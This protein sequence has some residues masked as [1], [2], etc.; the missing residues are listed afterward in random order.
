MVIVMSKKVFLELIIEENLKRLNIDPRLVDSFK[1]VMFKI[2]QYFDSHGYSEKIDFETIVN[3]YLL[4][5]ETVDRETIRRS[6]KFIKEL[7]DARENQKQLEAIVSITL[8]PIEEETFLD[9]YIKKNYNVGL[10]FKV[11]SKE[12]DVAYAGIYKDNVKTIEI[13]ESVL[14]SISTIGLDRVLCHEFIHFLTMCGKEKLGSVK[15]TMTPAIYEPLTEMLASDVIGIKPESYKSY[16]ELIRYINLLCGVNGFEYFIQR[17][18]DPKYEAME[19][20]FEDAQNIFDKHR[21]SRVF[22]DMEEEEFNDLVFN[23]TTQL[24]FRDYESVEELT[25]NLVKIYSAPQVYSNLEGYE[26]LQDGIV[27]MYLSEHQIT[28]PNVKVKIMQLVKVKN[29]R[30]VMNNMNCISLNISGDTY[31]FDENGNLYL[32]RLNTTFK[33]EKQGMLISYEVV[34]GV[35]K[36]YTETGLYKCDLNG[37][38]FKALG[39]NLANQQE[40][41]ER[42]IDILIKGE[43][44][45][46]PYINHDT[47]STVIGKDIGGKDEVLEPVQLKPKLRRPYIK[48][49][50]MPLLQKKIKSFELETKKKR[51]LAQKEMVQQMIAN[52]QVISM[53]DAGVV[54]EEEQ[55]MGMSL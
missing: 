3:D 46:S 14:S 32:K 54:E 28:N 33:Y 15:Q 1:R 11:D 16:R 31:L 5:R 52:Q 13:R 48:K 40:N 25:D 41:L 7:N 42:Q 24:L 34:D 9:E 36:L 45:S 21:F 29:E 38:D 53:R 51:L 20:V 2:Q 17:K 50:T 10:S 30:R 27:D 8:N 39:N 4:P 18:I 49:E 26:K 19:A 22:C 6:T 43:R 55:D 44:L 12:N 37:V 23:A 47:V 35:L